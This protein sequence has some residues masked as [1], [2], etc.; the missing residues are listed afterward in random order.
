M[1]CYMVQTGN[2]FI[3]DRGFVGCYMVQTGNL[4]Q[5]MEV[6]WDI[7]WYRPVICYRRYRF[8]GML[9]GTEW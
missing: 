7:I 9:Y 1:G 5:K 4:L 8:C 3:E 6:L 2:F